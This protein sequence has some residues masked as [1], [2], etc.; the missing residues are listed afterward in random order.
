MVKAYILIK[1]AAGMENEVLRRLLS[2]S[3]TEE[4][5]DVFGLYD[6]VAEVRARDMENI[7]DVVMDR[8]R[9]IDGIVDTQ[10]LLVT[11]FDLDMNS[12]GIAK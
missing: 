8:I 1:T 11:D 12:T 7:V 10:T 4:A 6:I 2:F 9:P 5:H 3:A